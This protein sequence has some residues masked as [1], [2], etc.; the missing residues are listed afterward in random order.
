MNQEYFVA[1]QV[2][3]LMI[4]LVLALLIMQTSH[5]IWMHFILIAA[6]NSLIV[7]GFKS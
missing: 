1:L 7:A 6:L 2:F 5:F 3:G 4:I